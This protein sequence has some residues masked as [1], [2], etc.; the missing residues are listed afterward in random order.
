MCDE[1]DCCPQ[2]CCP[3][4]NL[5]GPTGPMEL[6]LPCP[7]GPT[8]SKGPT[9]PT[10]KDAPCLIIDD[11]FVTTHMTSTNM[12]R[13]IQYDIFKVGKLV[14]VNVCVGSLGVSI[15]PG[16]NILCIS[17][18][19]FFPTNFIEWCVYTQSVNTFNE[20]KVLM[21][22]ENGL[23]CFKSKIGRASCRERV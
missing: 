13:N 4:M 15:L 1:C 20:S 10:G 8:G 7:T 2:D 18:P 23:L 11:D 22:H 5:P 17:D 16:E 19:M 6:C 21:K 14:T 12:P 9:G 3:P